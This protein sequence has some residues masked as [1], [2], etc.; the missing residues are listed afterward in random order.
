MDL[1]DKTVPFYVCRKRT[2]KEVCFALYFLKEVLQSRIQ[3]ELRVSLTWSTLI[4]D[5]EST[6]L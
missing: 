5:P 3:R 6:A 2:A 4:E 1:K